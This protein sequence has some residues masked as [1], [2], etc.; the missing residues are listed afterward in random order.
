M[1]GLDRMF[2]PSVVALIGATEREGSVGL[3]LLHNLLKSNRD[4]QVYPVNP[5]RESVLGIKCY[6]S[7]GEVPEHVDLAVVATPAKTVPAVV[8]ECGEAGVEGAVIV[9]AGFKETG[10]E[11]RRLEEEI[12]RL[13]Q[14]YGLRILGPNCLGFIRPPIGLNSTFL[15]KDPE[16]G[17]I[18][19]ISQSGALGSAILDWAVSAHV[20]FSMFVSLGSMLD[21]DFGD[22]IDFLGRDPYTRS[23]LIYM[24][25]VGNARKFM[26]AARGFARNKPIIVMK[27]GKS[28]AAARAAQ[29]HTGAMTGSF[30]V[31]R[32]A[33]RRAGVVRVDE[34]KDLFNCA[35]VLDSRR[36]PAGPRLAVITNAGGPGVIA[37][38]AVVE[39]GGVLAELSSQTVELLNRVL[40]PYWSG[41]NPIDVL[42]DA[43]VNRYS[44]AL[45][46]CLS[47][48][49]VDDIIVIY[50]PQ[51][52]AKPLDLAKEV[53][54]IVDESGRVK[55]VLTVWMGGDEVLPARELFY[56]NDIPTYSTP[57]EAVKTYTYIYKY[58]RNLELLY[59]TPEDLQIDPTPP[60]NF[61]K[62]LIRRELAEGRTVL[63]LD[64][65]DRF[66][67][68]YGI[69]R[70]KGELA[71][72]L[73]EALVIAA[74]L[75]Y[76]VALKIV[77]P[78]IVHK[79]DF[80][81]VVLNISSEAEL[82]EAFVRLVDSV[83]SRMPN[84]RV[85]GIYVQRMARPV[86]Y[87]L[88]LGSTRDPDFGA[89][90]LFGSGGTA[91]EYIRDYSIGLPPLNQV[92]ARRLMEETKIYSILARG[93][94]NKPPADMKKLEEIIV[95][96]SNMIVDFPEIREAEINP[97]IV[98]GDKAYAVDFRVV[99][100]SSCVETSEP[101]S[102]LVISP[103][104][105]RYVRPWRLRDGR[106]VL[107][108]PIR[109]EDEPLEYELIKGLS[110]ESSRFR[111]FQVIR[112]V[113]H[114]MLVRLCNI[115]YDREIAIIAEYSEGGRKRNVGVG[116]LIM[117]REAKRGEFAVL[118]ADDFQGVG[119]GTKL[120]DMIIEIAQERGLDSIY[121]IVLPENVKMIGLCRK[122]GFEIKHRGD[123]VYVELKLR[124]E[125]RG[126]GVAG[127]DTGARA[128]AVSEALDR[129]EQQ[130]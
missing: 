104:P 46:A 120:T 30:E 93:W 24:E 37:A 33:F 115:D 77:S 113:T 121:G 129:R 108:R 91:T 96:F 62:L 90:I 124:P 22:L 118:V 89:V 111:F 114:E 12:R 103:Y 123:E 69:P 38:D 19:F 53:I 56:R 6:P 70:A 105:T 32:A 43:D 5:N 31:Y 102:H 52:A 88:I 11:G 73:N 130:R 74:R 86:N 65:C 126:V 17:Q 50:T 45:R 55:P 76:P 23:I 72:S 42:G 8:A 10:E 78:D 79:T 116:R 14:K 9:S 3:A 81:G 2:N 64:K 13:R 7:I 29:S 106:E 54:N 122:L 128:R 27:P 34:I 49:Q 61:L 68:A 92:L 80:N 60:K 84:A 58:K 100:D 57:E 94:R 85:E 28:P 99:L 25:G 71:T 20:G 98:S 75:G 107:L 47:D 101:Y 39:Y 41:G 112:E 40:P 83:R 4:R 95:R 36:L 97:L 51:G 117:D 67:D 18:A 87:E 125:A 63:T 16:P 21:I 35:S 109:P 15:L 26:S 127:R 119:L 66:L 44:V 59:E 1:G 82:R 48:P 110:E